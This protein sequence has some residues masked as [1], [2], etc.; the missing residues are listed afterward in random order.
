MIGINAI[1]AGTFL[2]LISFA[3]GFAFGGS[4]ADTRRIMAFGTA[5][6]DLSA[7]LLV[8]VENFSD[9]AVAAMIVVVAL[10]GVGIQVPIAVTLGRRPSRDRHPM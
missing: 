7:A 1:L 4:S 3:C 5:Q 8:S 9:P 6:R 10:L 2:L